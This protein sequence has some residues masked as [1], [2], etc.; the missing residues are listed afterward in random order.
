M[1]YCTYTLARL[2]RSKTETLRK[3]RLGNGPYIVVFLQMRP[4]PDADFKNYAHFIV[5]NLLLSLVKCH[6]HN[7]LNELLIAAAV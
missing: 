1:T 7:Q 4:S 6:A 5:Q 2:R 3:K